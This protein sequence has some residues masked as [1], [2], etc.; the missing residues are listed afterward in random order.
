MLHKFLSCSGHPIQLKTAI[1]NLPSCFFFFNSVPLLF[2][3]AVVRCMWK[4]Q[5]NNEIFTLAVDAQD[6]GRSAFFVCGRRGQGS[7]PYQ[8]PVIKNSFPYNTN[9]SIPMG[10]ICTF[11]TVCGPA[12]PSFPTPGPHTFGDSAEGANET[13]H[14]SVA[15]GCGEE[16]YNVLPAAQCSEAAV[17]TQADFSRESAIVTG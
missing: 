8:V 10:P 15:E 13:L 11:S 17:T 9:F 16:E 5:A 2:L 3:A 6:S 14:R 1:G 12:F 4:Q 7:S